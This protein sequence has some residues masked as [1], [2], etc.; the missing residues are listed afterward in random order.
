MKAKDLIASSTAVDIL[1]ISICH[2]ASPHASTASRERRLS[3]WMIV[4]RPGSRATRRHAAVDHQ[5]GIAERLEAGV[6]HQR[7]P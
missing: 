6:E 5:G 7:R 4:A 3:R 1:M 2:C